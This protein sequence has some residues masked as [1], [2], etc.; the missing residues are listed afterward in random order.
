MPT[1][2]V[3]PLWSARTYSCATRP[4]P[5]SGV[6]M[7]RA[8]R[9]GPRMRS[10]VSARAKHREPSLAA[11]FASSRA[12]RRCV[13]RHAFPERMQTTSSCP[14]CIFRLTPTSSSPCHTCTVRLHR[15]S[16]LPSPVTP[17]RVH[18]IATTAKHLFQRRSVVV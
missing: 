9:G 16:Q 8:V 17:V 7:P 6:R 11:Y 12:T 10:A 13:P 4:P 14:S 1:A 15:A 2:V 5:V 18:A 3:A